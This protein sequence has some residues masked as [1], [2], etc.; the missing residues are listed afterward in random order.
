M[1]KSLE[2]QISGEIDAVLAVIVPAVVLMGEDLHTH[3]V[4][5]RTQLYHGSIFPRE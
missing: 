2:Q 4:G 5:P 1:A 3:F